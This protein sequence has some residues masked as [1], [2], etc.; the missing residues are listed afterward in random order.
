MLGWKLLRDSEVA[1]QN[2][3]TDAK[4]KAGREELA[5]LKIYVAKLEA[6]LEHERSRVEAERERA[7]R[8]S[9][10]VLQDKGLP[11]VSNTVI[12]EQRAVEDDVSAKRTKEMAELL[13][14]YGETMDEVGEEDVEPLPP[15]LAASVK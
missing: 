6:L 5:T 10:T 15:E 4:L 1:L 11:P 14:I 12:S 7:D 2:E 13:E 3:L 8:L 9:D